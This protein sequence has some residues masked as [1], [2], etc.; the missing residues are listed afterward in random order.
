MKTIPTFPSSLAEVPGKIL[1]HE[2]SP[3]SQKGWG[4]LVLT[5][6]NIIVLDTKSCYERRILMFSP[7]SQYK[8]LIMR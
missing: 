3:W 1:F 6:V 2:T 7:P 5:I 8:M 4:V